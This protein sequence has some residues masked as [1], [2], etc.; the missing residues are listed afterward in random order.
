MEEV[1]Q[2]CRSA[3]TIKGGEA[4]FEVLLEQPPDPVT[5]AG[6]KEVLAWI[7]PCLSKGEKAAVNPDGS[8]RWT[9]DENKAY[10]Q[11]KD[12]KVKEAI[13]RREAKLAAA[14][15]PASSH[16][17]S[18]QAKRSRSSSSADGWDKWEYKQYTDED[19][20]AWRKKKQH[21]NYQSWDEGY[22]HDKFSDAPWK[23]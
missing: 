11:Q 7:K 2:I 12:Q 5:P 20:E 3:R 6:E 15:A 22:K 4:I 1:V 18:Y 16:Q 23:S 13:K 21:E 14:D 9:R 10:R 17:N 19:Y 8:L